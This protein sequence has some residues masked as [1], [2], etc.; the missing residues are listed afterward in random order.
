MSQS[1]G[2]RQ[3]MSPTSGLPAVAQKALEAYAQGKK[4]G[5]QGL[6]ESFLRPFMSALRVTTKEELCQYRESILAH[7]AP[8]C[9]SR[10]ELS[11]TVSGVTG[12]TVYTEL[13]LF[14]LE[15]S[16]SSIKLS[17]YERSVRRA[18]QKRMSRE[19]SFLQA[20]WFYEVLPF[21]VGSM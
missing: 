12:T 9:L 19:W 5:K 8:F 20:L 18:A 10:K 3:D 13:E 17:S 6:R 14:Q 1:S 2:I 15:L 16:K 4:D 11:N 21:R 7:I